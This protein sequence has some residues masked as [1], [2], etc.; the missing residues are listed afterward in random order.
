LQLQEHEDEIESMGMNVVGLTFESRSLALAYTEETG[1]RW[2][3]LVDDARRLYQ[4]YGM[5]RGRWRDILGWSAWRIYAQLLLRGRRLR[6]TSGDVRQLGGDV[7]V[8]PAG[9]VRLLHVGAGP[10]DRPSVESLLD[11]VRSRQ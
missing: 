7:V 10:A 3:M 9:I 5:V 4:R 2:P 8:D 1:M 6:R 11:F